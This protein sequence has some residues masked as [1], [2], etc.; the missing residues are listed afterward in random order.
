MKRFAE[1]LIAVEHEISMEKGPFLL[2]ALFLHEEAAGYWDVVVSA[3][4]LEANHAAALKYLVPKIQ[5][6]TTPEELE[7]LSRIAIFERSRP[8]LAA[9]QSAVQIE[10]GFKELLRSDFNG[11]RIEHAYIITSRREESLV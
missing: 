11:L 10:H 4:W 2:F 6:V 9:I 5:A 3:P 1:K 7:K 8:A